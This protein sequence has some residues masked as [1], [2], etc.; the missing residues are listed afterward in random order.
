MKI[1]WEHR[2]LYQQN[3][4]YGVVDTTHCPI[5]CPVGD[6]GSF[7]YWKTKACALK[8]EVVVSIKPLRILW[9][10][11]SLKPAKHDL[12]I[13]R[14]NLLKNIGAHERFIADKAYIGEKAFITPLKFIITPEEIQWN[15]MHHNLQRRVE[16]VNR[17]L[18]C[19]RCVKEIWRHEISKHH[20]VFVVV[21]Q[22]VQLVLITNDENISF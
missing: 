17:R 2:H 4:I 16:W 20:K 12:T 8:Y 3:N 13:S 21:A 10:N 18:K 6:Y 19:F 14:E 22:L 9:V 7:Y 11:G 5:E 1:N 15:K